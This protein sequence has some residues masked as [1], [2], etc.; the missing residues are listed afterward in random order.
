MYVRDAKWPGLES[1]KFPF[2][3]D[4]DATRVLSIHCLLYPQDQVCS[5][6]LKTKSAL[7]P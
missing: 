4:E 7:T 3:K 1:L 5:E 6:T 2:S